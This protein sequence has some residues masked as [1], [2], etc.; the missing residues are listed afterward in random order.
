MRGL[1]WLVI[2]VGVAAVGVLAF[3]GWQAA[4]FHTYEAN[5]QDSG[6]SPAISDDGRSVRLSYVGGHCDDHASV[7]VDETARIVTLTVKVFEKYGSCDDVGVLH[8][9]TAHL[10]HPVGDRELRDGAAY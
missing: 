10:E 7:D 6:H 2:V 1:R 8:E 3:R 5:W 4:R 9:I